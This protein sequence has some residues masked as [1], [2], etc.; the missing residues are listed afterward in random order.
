[1]SQQVLLGEE[2]LC[3]AVLPT[4]LWA[5]LMALS[6]QS[7]KTETGTWAIAVGELGHPG[8][9]VTNQL[10]CCH[11]QHT[12]LLKQEQGTQDGLTQWWLDDGNRGLSLRAP[13]PRSTQQPHRPLQL[14]S[15]SVFFFSNRRDQA[16]KRDMHVC[17]H[18]WSGVHVRV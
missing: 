1:M 2:D 11:T 9:T 18:A 14:L 15:R 6:A 16:S 3:S 8:A 4:K 13:V 12:R 10:C 7:G 5:P 17:L